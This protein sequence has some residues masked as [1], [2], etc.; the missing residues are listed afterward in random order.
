MLVGGCTELY[1]ACEVRAASRDTWVPG[2]MPDSLSLSVCNE[3]PFIL[4]SVKRKEQRGV[5]M[6]STGGVQVP[7]APDLAVP[8]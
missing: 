1:C 3:R 5:L 8:C 2:L 7:G 6:A 4:T